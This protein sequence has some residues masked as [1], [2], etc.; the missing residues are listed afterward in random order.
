MIY[1]LGSTNFKLLR[2][3]RKEA[4]TEKNYKLLSDTQTEAHQ[5]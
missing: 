1:N 3:Y 5:G 2:L 4:F